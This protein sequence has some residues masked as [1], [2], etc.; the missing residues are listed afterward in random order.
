MVPTNRYRQRESRHKR[1]RGQHNPLLTLR[2]RKSVRSTPKAPPVL[3]RGESAVE[4]LMTRKRAK[5]RRRFDVSLSI[6]GAEM[7]L[8]SLPVMRVGWRLLSGL[9]VLALAGLMYFLWTSPMFKVSQPSVVGVQRV[10]PE[11]INTLLGINGDSIFSVNPATIYQRIQQVY[12]Q[13]SAITVEVRLPAT[14]VIEVKERIPVILWKRDGLEFWLDADGYVFPPKGDGSGLVAIEG[15]LAGE[16]TPVSGTA[17][18][19]KQVRP[20][21]SSEMV[22]AI[23]SMGAQLPKKASLIFDAQHGLGWKETRG[24]KV[25]FGFDISNIGTKIAVYKAILKSL[26]RSGVKPEIISVEYVD[27]PYYRAER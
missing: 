27:A 19:T 13:M 22:T 5:N 2:G 1:P 9:L 18:T 24:A 3:V 4:P 25:Y 8:P 23:L 10:T 15:E 12:P 21:I 14:V 26:N 17:Y 6:P 11:E 20:L 16:N 7:R